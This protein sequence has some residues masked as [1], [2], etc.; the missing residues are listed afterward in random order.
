MR[1]ARAMY[2]L[3]M[4]TSRLAQVVGRDEQL[5]V[6]QCCLVEGAVAAFS[7]MSRAGV[8]PASSSTA[9]AAASHSFRSML[10]LRPA[11]AR[12]P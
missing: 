9:A 10:R 6:E 7:S 11:K 3:R 2:T 1:V 8:G 12:S 5:R 4:Y